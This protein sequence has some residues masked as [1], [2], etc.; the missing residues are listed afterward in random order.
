MRSPAILLPL[1]IASVPGFFGMGVNGIFAFNV[2]FYTI[3]TGILLYTLLYRCTKKAT[4]LSVLLSIG[5]TAYVHNLIIRPAIMQTVY[6]AFLLFLIAFLLYLDKPKSMRRGIEVSITAALGFYMYLYVW[7]AA[8]TMIGLVLLWSIWKRNTSVI[9]TQ[10]VMWPSIILLCLPQIILMLQDRS[11]E[12][13]AE[14]TYRTGLIQTHI[15]HPLTILN[16]KYVIFTALVLLILYRKKRWPTCAIL[17]FLANIAL[18]ITATSNIFT[19]VMLDLST[20]PWRLSLIIAPLAIAVFYQIATNKKWKTWER[21]LAGVS[22]I[23][24][25]ATAIQHTAIRGNAFVYLRNTQ[26]RKVAYISQ[27]KFK[28]VLDFLWTLDPSRQ[29]ILT[30]GRIGNFIP[31][32]TDH[33]LLFHGTGRFNHIPTDEFQERFLIQNVDYVDPQFIR[34]NVRGLAGIGP[35]REQEYIEACKQ[36]PFCIPQDIEHPIEHI[37][38]D[39]F[40]KK[41]MALHANID[42]SYEDHLQKF[43]VSLIVQDT[44][45]E[46]QPRM[47]SS[48]TQIYRDDRFTIWQL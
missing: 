5:G 17:V 29:V 39:S 40:V 31:L 3:L 21:T 32:Y 33:T 20:H 38:G 1:W 28:P 14:L 43:N 10:L 22:A 23:I 36:L 16:H 27:Q 41:M 30:T 2:Y 6:P 25:L 15:I 45:S 47:P 18:L 9:K 7:M 44:E 35:L 13:F 46:L 26:A 19:G 34:D 4:T 48:A 8:F 42:N 24:L 37:G 11:N 12:L